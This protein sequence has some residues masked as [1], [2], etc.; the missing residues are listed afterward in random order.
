MSGIARIKD[1]LRKMAVPRASE[2]EEFLKIKKTSDGGNGFASGGIASLAAGSVL[3]APIAPR[4]WTGDPVVA[5]PALIPGESA[6]TFSGV[7]GGAA[8]LASSMSPAYGPQA[9]EIS[10][11]G[12]ASAMSGQA[13]AAIDADLYLS[14][15]VVVYLYVPPD[16]GSIITITAE[17]GQAAHATPRTATLES[18]AAVLHPGAGVVVVGKRLSEFT[19]GTG[20][21]PADEVTTQNYAT[22]RVK[23]ATGTNPVASKIQVLH[24]EIIRRKKPMVCVTADD[25]LLSMRDIGSKIYNGQGIP[26]TCYLIAGRLYGNAATIS[27]D[28]ARRLREKGNAMCNH[29]YSHYNISEGMTVWKADVARAIDELTAQGFGDGARHLAWVQGS[30]NAESMAAA[31]EIGLLSA[32]NVL[33][34]GIYGSRGFPQPYDFGGIE[35]QNRTDAQV[36]ALVDLEINRGADCAI[37]HHEFSETENSGIISS[38]AVATAIAKGLRAR[39]DAGKC[40][41]GTIPELYARRQAERRWALGG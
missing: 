7:N 12:G 11:P 31:R 29:T 18:S 2:G 35:T 6:L 10:V 20:P 40:I 26:M 36:L 41:L 3:L 24:A 21:L 13:T 17:L 9:V 5:R 1:V 32:R 38:R 37:L 4:W 25:G 39:A 28:D 8:A 16:V 30:R 33:D 22:L 34:R 27:W 15:T 23:A 14:D 19:G